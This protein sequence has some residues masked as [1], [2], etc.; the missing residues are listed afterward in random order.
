MKIT[1][2]GGGFGG[3]KAALRLAE[4]DGNKITLISD[5]KDFQYFPALYATAT[6]RSKRQS[7]IPLGEIFANKPNVNVVIDKVTSIDPAKKT[8]TGESGVLYEYDNCILALGA[9]TTYFNIKGLDTY[10]FGIKSAEEIV[11]LKQHLF[12]QMSQY[13]SI[14]KQ[15]VIVGGGPTGVEL[16][17]TLGVYLRQLQKKYTRSNSKINITLIEGSPRLLPR[18]HPRTSSHV[19]KRLRK[20]GVKVELNKRVE[21]STAKGLIVSGRPIETQTI[22]WT[23]GVANN[24]FFAD[25]AKHFT[26]AKNGKVEVDAQ[27]R[28]AKDVYVI[29]DNAATPFSGL[30]QVALHDAHFVADN[31]MRKIGHQPLKKYKAVMPPVVVPLGEWWAVFEWR[32]IRMHGVL[33][34][35]IRRAADIVGYSDILPLGHALDIWR[36]QDRPEDEYFTPLPKRQR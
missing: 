26:F 1:I 20:I 36:T 29:G 18:M 3:V 9:V 17:A 23:S 12:E 16:A 11:R 32:Q 7:W 4:Y 28:V 2:C 6:G 22:I 13:Q 33:A 30:A 19:A 34:A 35:L 10:A 5:K 15:Y 31:L 14:D 21:A 27:L 24:P 25:N 8:L